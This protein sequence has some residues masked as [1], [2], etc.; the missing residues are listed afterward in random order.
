MER[1][2]HELGLDLPIEVLFRCPGFGTLSREVN[3]LLLAPDRK[4]FAPVPLDA[5]KCHRATP[6]QKRLWYLEQLNPQSSQFNVVSAHSVKGALNVTALQLA[7]QWL[8]ARHDALLSR[9]EP[10]DDEI[11]MVQATENPAFVALDCR[12]FG[13]EKVATLVQKEAS[14]PFELTK[15]PLSRT[16]IFQISELESIVLFVFHHAIVDGWSMDIFYEELALGY[17]HFNAGGDEQKLG[18]QLPPVPGFSSY[19]AWSEDPRTRSLQD[20]H[21]E[22]WKNRLKSAP[23]QIGLPS[24][25]PQDQVSHAAANLSVELSQAD[26]R[27]LKELG[28]RH[29]ITLFHTLLA[30]YKLLLMRLT[31]ESDLIVGVPMARRDI[32]GFKGTMGFLVNTLAVR[33]DLSGATSLADIMARVR[34]SMLESQSHGY[35]DFDAV[36]QAVNPVRGK[37]PSALFRSMFALNPKSSASPDLE[38]LKV[39]EWTAHNADAK[40]DL[41]FSWMS[42]EN[43]LGADVEYRAELYSEN[44][45][46]DFVARLL[47]LARAAHQNPAQD[48]LQVNILLEHETTELWQST[49][50]ERI[51]GAVQNIVAAFDA[52][53]ARTPE[54]TAIVEGARTLSYKQLADS[55]RIVRAHLQRVGAEP[56]AIIA[57]LADRSLE[58]VVVWL[59]ILRAGCTYLPLDPEQPRE[60]LEAIL[61][62]ASCRLLLQA[63]ETTKPLAHDMARTMAFA[64]VLAPIDAGA[65]PHLLSDLATAYINYTSGSTGVPKGIAVPHRGVLRLVVNCSFQDYTADDRIAF[66][67]NVAFDAAT[68]DVWGGLLNGACVVVVPRSVVLDPAAF[69]K[70]LREQRITSMF[71]TVSLF[72]AMMGEMPE[73]FSTLSV[74]KVGGDVMDGKAVSRLF[75]SGFQG[76]MINCYGPTEATTYATTHAVDRGPLIRRIPIG[77]PIAATGVYIL[78]DRLQ[79]LPRGAT[80]EICISGD[81]L[82]NYYV[83]R[84]DLTAE[85][86]VPNPRLGA[87]GE[88][89]YRTGD[90]GRILED[91]TLEFVGRKDFQVKIRGFR[92]E[93]EEIASVINRFPG[94]DQV[95]VLV[96]SEGAE[97]HLAAFYTL[98]D[99]VADVN[100]QDLRTMTRER[101]PFYMTPKIFI[102]VDQF[103]LTPNGKLDRKS[104]LARLDAPRESPREPTRLKS[105]REHQLYQ[106]WSEVLGHSNFGGDDNFFDIGGTSLAALKIIARARRFDLRITIG[107]VLK[108]QTLSALATAIDEMHELVEEVLVP[109]HEGGG[110]TPFFCVHP[111]GGHVFRMAPLA[112]TLDPDRPFFGV[113][114][115]GLS[116]PSRA[117]DDIVEMARLYAEAIL[118]KVPSGPIFL[119]GW[120]LG[121]VIAFEMTRILEAEGRKVEMLVILDAPAP[122]TVELKTEAEIIVDEVMGYLHA[123]DPLTASR[124]STREL[125]QTVKAHRG[126]EIEA[127]MEKLADLGFTLAVDNG[128]HMLEQ[129]LA[130]QFNAVKAL[131]GYRTEGKVDAPIG[132]ITSEDDSSPVLRSAREAGFGWKELTRGGFRQTATV[133]SHETMMDAVH[134]VR[135]ADAINQWLKEIEQ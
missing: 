6:G 91:H 17:S 105:A 13:Q 118:K 126:R 111:S 74:L 79:M 63:H 12:D 55:S 113:Q 101:L 11:M 94:M 39:E 23:E 83:G 125:L 88:R 67:S 68:D 120:S 108:Y 134:A 90:L 70:I 133:G 61:R 46:R 30:L 3:Q 43:A 123:H 47:L 114:A 25:R 112:A 51:H 49:T 135:L 62:D 9:F 45:V 77:R 33:T 22:F 21:L 72:H 98:R 84:P 16:A 37:D 35:A 60:R 31:G 27:I 99:A 75:E 130:F 4:G 65:D 50:H 73:S 89:L 53:A 58:T 28:E 76:K 81:G 18:R 59:G 128:R 41:T 2:N 1:I 116:D 119:N 42:S 82:A 104:L 131:H 124:M 26:V 132:L 100:E 110:K 80:G 7:I 87:V 24:R 8:G 14:R 57:V 127:L 38:G 15:E 54:Q 66:I 92:V 34:L 96:F 109:L 122:G 95:E 10:V 78:D 129:A 117:Q 86:F 48:P 69:R 36:V 32:S 106:I 40:Y 107:H 93:P 103:P 102:Q 19:A 71:L 64:E 5:P 121:G 115:I 52:V 56:G 85:K 97:K 44:E 20:S 29:G